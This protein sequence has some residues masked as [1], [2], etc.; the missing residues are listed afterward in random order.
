[1]ASRTHRPLAVSGS[2]TPTIMWDRIIGQDVA[3]SSLRNAVAAGT[4]SHAYLFVGPQGLGKI[5]A[6]QALA[7]AR[8]C[9]N[10]TPERGGCGECDTCRRIARGTHPDVTV[11]EP[12]G[13]TGY[14]AEQVRSLIH[15]VSLAPM[16]APHKVVIVRSADLFNDSS[17]NAFLKTLE[18]PPANV[19]IVLL[20][21]TVEPIIPT[22]LSRCVTVRFRP[23]P[24]AT[25]IDTLVSATGASADEARIALAATGSV[26][27][28]A[29]AHLRSHA[30]RSGR[31]TVVRAFRDLPDAD[32]LDVMN[33]ARDILVGIKG[34][35]EEMRQR[36][37]LEVAAQA[38]VLDRVAIKTLEG[39]NKRRLSA[40]ERQS[41]GE[42]LN[43]IG[44]LL[45]DVLAL[46]QDADDMVLNSD[47]VNDLYRF[48]VCVTPSGIQ[49][50]YDALSTARKRL[51]Q[52]VGIQLTLEAVLFDIREVLQCR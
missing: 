48:S 29:E 18:E 24:L 8:M 14:L 35:V 23:L 2:V 22:I 6:A 44:S 41:V 7:A 21:H 46:S 15:E 49:R 4:A 19:T 52:N 38:E 39:Y 20:A 50:G 5:A 9:P 37:E 26:L 10:R 17:A 28:E 30:R 45:R 32:D 47:V 40:F 25:M 36:Q 42:V 1:M 16:E 31:A 12:E 33:F 43:I 27:T 3:L 34:P 13:A 11:V 51:A